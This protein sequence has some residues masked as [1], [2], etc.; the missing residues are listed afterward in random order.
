MYIDN[1]SPATIAEVV[2]TTPRPEIDLA[3]IDWNKMRVGMKAMEDAYNAG[4]IP[5]ADESYHQLPMRDGFTST[6]KIHKPV[7]AAPGP[8]IALFFGGGFVCGSLEQFTR[9]ARA[10]NKVLG[11]TVVSCAYRLA[12]EYQFPTGQLDALDSMKWI[13]ENATGSLL[14]SDPSKGFIIGGVSLLSPPR[15]CLTG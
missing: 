4:A 7:D 15:V 11:A 2:N 5:A 1:M 9:T 3:N 8:L 14:R 10:L 12:P 13:A 6:I